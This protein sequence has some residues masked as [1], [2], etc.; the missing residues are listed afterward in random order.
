MSFLES[1][2]QSQGA[3]PIDKLTT[4][5][6]AGV[7]QTRRGRPQEK[8]DRA[9]R[10]AYKDVLFLFYLHQQVNGK[11]V[12]ESDVYQRTVHYPD[13]WANGYHVMFDSEE[14]VTARVDQVDELR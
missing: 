7:K 10:Q 8:I 6:E 3:Y 5:V 13:E 9:V 2:F 12:I 4:Q 11:L 1:A 14:L